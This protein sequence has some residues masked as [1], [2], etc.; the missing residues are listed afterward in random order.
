MVSA[1]HSGL[2]AQLCYHMCTSTSASK[3]ANVP[4]LDCVLHACT[5]VGTDTTIRWGLLKSKVVPP[6]DKVHDAYMYLPAYSPTCPY[7][8]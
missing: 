4:V 5:G 6:K 2:F 1:L 8:L 7:L 3:H